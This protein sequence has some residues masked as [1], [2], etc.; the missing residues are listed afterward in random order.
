VAKAPTAFASSLRPTDAEGAPNPYLRYGTT[1]WG[2]D[3]IDRWGGWGWR[4]IQAKHGWDEDDEAATRD[5]LATPAATIEQSPTSMRY[6]GE[7]YPQNGADCERVVTVEYGVHP[8][9]PLG[10]PKGIITSYGR[11]VP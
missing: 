4:H 11:V 10:T 7:V 1:A 9:D 8:G 6:I 2:G 3:H 5:A